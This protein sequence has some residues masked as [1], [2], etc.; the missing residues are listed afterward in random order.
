[1]CLRVQ[2]GKVAGTHTLLITQCREVLHFH[3]IVCVI[4]DAIGSLDW[5]LLPE[6]FKDVSFH[7]SF[8]VK[9]GNMRCCNFSINNSQNSCLVT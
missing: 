3:Q 9:F 4:C 8:R 1:M 6:F 5:S 2:N 7:V